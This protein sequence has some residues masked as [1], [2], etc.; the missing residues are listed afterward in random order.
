[1]SV[2]KFCSDIKEPQFLRLKIASWL[3]DLTNDTGNELLGNLATGATIGYND[4]CRCPP[5]PPRKTKTTCL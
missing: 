5:V 3:A 2:A 4:I 1:M